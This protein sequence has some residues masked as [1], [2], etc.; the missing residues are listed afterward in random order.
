MAVAVALL[1]CLLV[2]E[3]L[4]YFHGTV[5]G[6]GVQAPG[7][8][9]TSGDDSAA[10]YP[11]GAADDN[12]GDYLMP[13]PRG[14][15]NHG[16]PEVVADSRHRGLDEVTASSDHETSTMHDTAH[17]Q[18]GGVGSFRA[19][20]IAV[21]RESAK[22][23]C[24]EPVFRFC[25]GGPPEVY[26][27]DTSHACVE[28]THEVPG[29]CNRGRNRFTSMESCRHECMDGKPPA[30][31]CYQKT[32]FAECQA[33]DVVDSWW[34]YLEGK[35]CR[36]W[37]FP[38]GRCPSPKADVFRTSL[39]CVRRCA[40]EPGRRRGPCRVPATVLCDAQQ[41]R[42]G[43]FADEAT[44]GSGARLC[45]EV[46]SASDHHARQQCLVGANRFPT[47][48]ACRKACLRAFP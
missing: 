18:T 25:S 1:I 10:R 17:V 29:L 15:R 38:R 22:P 43:V 16:V 40:D 2:A 12:H 28:L 19:N 45:R 4:V 26:Y 42:F 48:E 21:L 5:S 11:V 46:P 39:E 23:A 27:N 24:E 14:T 31:E 32:V 44:D 13:A 34:W 9:P 7:A 37:R 30:A 8:V 47:M 20:G 6:S 35:G 3:L 33:R 41:L 36:R